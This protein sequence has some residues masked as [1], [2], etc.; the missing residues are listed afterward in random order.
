MLMLLQWNFFF[1]KFFIEQ[2]LPSMPIS[3]HPKPTTNNP[4]HCVVIKNVKENFTSG[5]YLKFRP[6]QAILLLG[7]AAS[8]PCGTRAMQ[9][10]TSQSLH[11][12]LSTSRP[13]GCLSFLICTSWSA[14]FPWELGTASKMSMMSVSL[15][16]NSEK[17]FIFRV[18]LGQ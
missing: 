14:P 3:L 2:P 8:T 12:C 7:V 10:F 9:R 11:L 5:F 17:F 16:R 4:L 18:K 15:V 13:P 6:L 1:H